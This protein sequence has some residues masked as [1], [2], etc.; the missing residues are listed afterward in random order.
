LKV[1][2][3]RLLVD[4]SYT[5]TQCGSTGV[6]RVV[7]RLLREFQDAAAQD[8][9]ACQPIAT[10]SKGFRLAASAHQDDRGPE[11]GTDGGVASQILRKVTSG[12]ARELAT[13]SLPV[14]LL[15]AAW[16]HYSRWTFD[17]LSAGAEPAVQGAGDVVFMADA[18]WYY[19]SWHA[20]Q[21]AR[22]RGA[23]PVLMVHDLIP[24]THPEHCTPLV[25]RMFTHWLARMLE[26]CDAVI[27]N[28]QATQGELQVYAAH[29]N[30]ALPPMGSFR[31]GC[32]PAPPQ[33]VNGGRARTEFAALLGEKP[34]FT[35]VGSLE[36]RKNHAFLLLV[37]DRLWRAGHDVQLLIMGRPAADGRAFLKRATCHPECGHRLRIVSDAND[38]ELSYAYGH[39]RALV[40]PSLAEGFGLPLVEARTRGCPVIA[41]DLPAFREL[42]DEGVWLHT[43]NSIEELSALVIAHS[44]EDWRTRVAPMPAFTWSDSAQE[45]LQVLGGLLAR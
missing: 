19:Q 41:S 38:D 26:C 21:L 29:R 44:K 42:S 7:R 8:T 20:A 28:S 24:L 33:P 12:R 3:K 5:R 18:A 14:P 39:S 6:T 11:S 10:H 23:R 45:C 37:F 13:R 30:L 15:E 22:T 17:H 2:F 40:F 4:V 25:S 34:T 36:P 16:R 1:P 9:W 43:P 31:L 32:D 35:A 27:C